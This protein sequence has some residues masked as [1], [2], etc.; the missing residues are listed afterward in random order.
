MTRLLFAF[1]LICCC[2]LT[3]VHAV[4][5]GLIEI[6]IEPSKN[7]IHPPESLF[8][9]INISGL[10]SGGID[11]LLG[12]WQMDFHYDADLF[13]PL[14][15]PPA[16]WGGKLGN[17]TNGETVGGVDTSTP[18]VIDIFEVSL[19]FDFELDSFPFQR[20]LDGNLLDSFR[21]ATLGFYAPSGT[22]FNDPS[23]LLFT[24]NI[25]LSDAY[26]NV[27]SDVNGEIIPVQH[28]PVSIKIPEPATW[29]LF[30]IGFI[31]LLRFRKMK[32]P[33]IRMALK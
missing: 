33:M 22:G 30:G 20:D 28:L 24:D 18:G 10:Q 25:V 29:V 16:G 2:A 31:G 21:L 27:L 5:V 13:N 7:K 1:V 32:R 15:I 4:P 11:N 9:D 17:I 26:G 12:A 3:T 14:N 19:L 8:V 23:T 6:T